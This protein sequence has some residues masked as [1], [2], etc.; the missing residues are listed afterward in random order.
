VVQPLLERMERWLAA[1]R[2]DYF[3]QLQPGVSDAQLDAF[4]TQFSLTLPV[5]L[6]ALYR[7]RNGQAEGNYKSLQMNRMFSSLESA[8]DSK[9][10]LDGMIG[11]D[12]TGRNGGVGAECRSCPTAGAATC[13]SMWRPRTE[14]S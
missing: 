10:L 7:W 6:R 4:E 2:P 3:E 13:A 5:A 8:A 1:N 11:S 14:D 12:S 9:E